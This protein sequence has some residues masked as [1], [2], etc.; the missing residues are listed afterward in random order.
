MKEDC[1]LI[2]DGLI[3]R[4]F[5]ERSKHEAEIENVFISVILGGCQTHGMTE[6]SISFRR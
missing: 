1:E 4:W 5:G 6:N 3:R 2:D